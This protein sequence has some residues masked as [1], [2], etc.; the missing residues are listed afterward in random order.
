VNPIP[1]TVI[2]GYLGAGKTTLLNALL[3]N[4]SG[5]RFAVLVN[6]FGSINVDAEAIA[7]TGADT[8]EL[9]NGCTCCTI[10]GDLVLALKAVLARP[11]P[12]DAIVIE[13][14]GVA[15]PA[16]VARLAA[17]HPALGSQVT[18]VVADAETIRA[19]VDDKYVGGL[20]R[21]QLH[22]ADAIVLAKADLVSAEALAELRAWFESMGT[23]VPVF[24]SAGGESIPIQIVADGSLAASLRETA[25]AGQDDGHVATFVTAAYRCARPLDRVRFLEAIPSMTHTL[26]RAKGTVAFAGDA[27]RHTFQL[28]GERWSIEPAVSRESDCETRIV[29]IALAAQEGALQGTLAA[30][31]HAE[32]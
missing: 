28:A 13:A 18:I 21:R 19:R 6:D 31:R 15:D 26:V 10:G 27:R 24:Q 8:I 1:V 16:A 30:L 5:T 3:R 7:S 4:E 12:P 11:E 23:G 14:S 22:V 17:C 2:G 32:T 29:A 9:T 20:V 25:D